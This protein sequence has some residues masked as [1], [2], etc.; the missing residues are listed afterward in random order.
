MPQPS[1][2]GSKSSPA[3][4]LVATAAIAAERELHGR[5]DDDRR[6]P[7]TRIG[8]F[9]ALLTRIDAARAGLP[10]RLEQLEDELRTAHD[11]A[12]ALDSAQAQLADVAGRLAAARDAERLGV[13]AA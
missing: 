1:A 6:R 2:S 5:R 7:A 10:E 11:G 13:G 8:E 4:W 9:E 3:T 12:G